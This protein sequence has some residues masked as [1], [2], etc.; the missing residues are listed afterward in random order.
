MLVAGPTIFMILARR[1]TVCLLIASRLITEYYEAVDRFAI[2]TSVAFRRTLKWMICFK[3]LI[4]EKLVVALFAL[5]FFGFQNHFFNLPA[6]SAYP[7]MSTRVSRFLL[8][9]ARLTFR[10][11]IICATSQGSMVEPV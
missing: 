8:V 5:Q 2:W 9:L 4:S 3:P 6:H 1:S 7:M 11:I 10:R